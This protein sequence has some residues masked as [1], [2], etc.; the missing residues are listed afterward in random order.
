MFVIVKDHFSLEESQN[1]ELLLQLSE[2]RKTFKILKNRKGIQDQTNH[3]SMLK[4]FVLA[5]SP[6]EEE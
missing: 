3:I 1:C 2:D 4:H 5:V 6:T